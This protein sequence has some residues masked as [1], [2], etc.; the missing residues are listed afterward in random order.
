MAI[1]VNAEELLTFT[2]AARHPAFR[3]RNG[4]RPHVSKVY[5]AVLYG[6]KSVTGQTV[7]LE[8]VRLPGGLHTS[9]E[10]IARFVARLNDDVEVDYRGPTASEAAVL[11]EAELDAAG[12]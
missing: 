11:A 6:S 10:A 9:T 3:T 2:Q 12:I 1:D 7:K 4:S 5:R 8:N